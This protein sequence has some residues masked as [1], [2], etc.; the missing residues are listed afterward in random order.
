MP[1][2]D[3]E[4]IYKITIITENGELLDS[5]TLDE[6]TYLEDIEYIAEQIYDEI[7]KSERRIK[8]QK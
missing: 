5:Y 3:E 8:A 7:Q 2:G 4:M 6:T 1:Q